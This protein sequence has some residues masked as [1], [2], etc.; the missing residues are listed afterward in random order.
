MVGNKG[1]GCDFVTRAHEAIDDHDY[2]A[3]RGI[4]EESGG[5]DALFDRCGAS[6]LQYAAGVGDEGAVKLLL[7]MGCPLSLKSFDE[8]GMSPLV[9]AAWGGHARV[10]AMLL[11]AGVH[12]D[13]RRVSG[14]DDTALV[15]AVARMN[16]EVVRLLLA[17]GADPD[18]E[19]WM[20]LSARDHAKRS[21]LER[22]GDAQVARVA[23]MLGIML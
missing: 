11:K 20:S 4:V 23:A 17:A 22:P 19:C 1:D 12:V 10:V 21:L 2:Q 18:L 9:H 16:A 13:Q 6:V 7:D 8:D 3:L 14:N 5:A 15:C